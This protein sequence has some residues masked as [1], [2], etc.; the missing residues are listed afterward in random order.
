MPRTVNGTGHGI[1]LALAGVA[2]ARERRENSTLLHELVEAH[3]LTFWNRPPGYSPPRSGDGSHLRRMDKKYKSGGSSSY[4]FAQTTWYARGVL[5]SR[6]RRPR[7]WRRGCP[8]LYG[9]VE[10]LSQTHTPPPL[11]PTDAF[12]RRQPVF[13]GSGGPKK[14]CEG[15]RNCVV[16][17]SGGWCAPY[18]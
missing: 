16:V 17:Y 9:G 7:R 6:R 14:A 2:V 15:A 18:R 11:R 8:K 3:G 10:V 12:R 1:D 4:F 13:G 5:E